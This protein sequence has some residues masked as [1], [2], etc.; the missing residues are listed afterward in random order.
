[1]AYTQKENTGSLFKNDKKTGEKQPDY[2]GTI[3]IAGREMRIAGWLR[4][5]TNGT[6]FMS[7]QI[8]EKM[9]APT[10]QTS[11]PSPPAQ[12]THYNNEAPF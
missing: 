5:S 8:S 6:P 7:L 3:N 12:P 10:T 11:Q 9:P 4:T 2:Q 1:M